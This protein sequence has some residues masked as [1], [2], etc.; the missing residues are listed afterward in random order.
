LQ[1]SKKDRRYLRA[2]LMSAPI[3]RRRNKCLIK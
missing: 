3:F 1:N 2:Y